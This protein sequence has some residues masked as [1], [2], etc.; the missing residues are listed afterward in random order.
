MIFVSQLMGIPV[1][2]RN[3][4]EIGVL[5]D[6]VVY[7]NE[8]HYPPVGGF[9]VRDRRRRIFIPAQQLGALSYQAIEIDTT[10]ISLDMFVRYSSTKTS[11]ITRL[12]TSTVGALCA[13]TTCK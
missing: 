6:I 13:S 1:I 12:S 9:V 5:H 10:R 11:L 7:I 3:G 4:D 8:H 2:A